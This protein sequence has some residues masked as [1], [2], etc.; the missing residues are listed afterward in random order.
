MTE[1]YSTGTIA[2]TN[3]SVDFVGAGT[4]WLPAN[5]KA[6]DVMNVAGQVM[7]VVEITDPTHG[8]FAIA[9]PGVTASGLGYAIV[10]TSAAWG[11]N[12][13]IAVNTAELVQLLTTGQ[14]FEWVMA[15]SHEDGVIG[16]QAGVLQL[17]IPKNIT[18]EELNLSLNQPSDSGNVSLD[19]RLDGVSILSTKLTVDQGETDSDTATTPYLLTQT[20]WNKG[21][22]LRIDFLTAGSNAAGAKLTVSGQRRN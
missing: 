9:Y 20:N 14:L 15:L 3:G 10:K 5:V 11:T 1:F 13:E 22:V 17:R 19:L 16:E 7:V 21:Q 6:G 18:V 12:R 4:T 8:K 2:V